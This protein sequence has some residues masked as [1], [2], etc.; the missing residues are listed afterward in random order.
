M[1]EI[2][3]PVVL[4]F[5]A[6]RVEEEAIPECLES[7][8]MEGI[9]DL[10][11]LARDEGLAA[12]RFRGL[13]HVAIGRKVTRPNGTVISSGITWRELATHL[14]ELQFDRELARTFGADPATLAPRDRER[15]W[16]SA[17]AQA[18]VDTPEASAEADALAVE[19]KKRGFI[20]GPNPAG[21][22]PSKKEEPGVKAPTKL[23]AKKKKK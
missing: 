3:E 15:F 21:I 20:V 22:L 12:A 23:A 5:P 9:R 7:Q 2:A 11:A 17:I 19:L 16:Y 10:L 6:P 14:K 13:L 4:Q 8:G 1:G 18:H